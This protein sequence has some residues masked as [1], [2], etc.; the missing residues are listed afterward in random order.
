MSCERGL[1]AGAFVLRALPD[2]E[3][4]AFAAHVATCPH[5]SAEVEQLQLVVDTLPVAAPQVA[6]PP[7]LKGR[8]MAIVESEAQL[9]RA[10]APDPLPARRRRR[11]PA[12]R[13]PPVAAFAAACVVLAV[14]VVAGAILR[15]EDARTRTTAAQVAGVRGASAAL[16]VRGDRASL[17]VA[18]LPRPG[19]GRVYQVWLQR[20]GAPQPTHTLFDVR[21]DGRAVVQISESMRGVRRVLVTAEPSGGSQVPSS[22][23]IIVASPA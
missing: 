11:P 1:D 23:P 15:D 3:Q 17:R 13:M 18:G 5:C 14:G 19:R 4:R 2:D 10:A 20:G 7:E 22:A 16:V 21:P 12:L 8:L 6:P 9:L